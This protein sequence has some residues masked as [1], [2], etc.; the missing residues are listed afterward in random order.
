MN[1]KLVLITLLIFSQYIFTKA[2]NFQNLQF[3]QSC[4]DSLSGACHWNVSWQYHTDEIHKVPS[5]RGQSLLISGLKKSSIGFIEQAA[6]V[7]GTPALKLLTFSGKIKTENLI[8]KGAE[9]TISTYDQNKQYLFVNDLGK[10]GKPLFKG[11]QDWQ[12]FQLQAI[13]SKEVRS[14]HLGAI[15]Y[16]QG[17]AWF[18][19]FNIDIQPLTDRTPSK[20]AEEYINHFCN[21]V[22]QNSIR[23]DSID[24]PKLRAEA[25]QIAGQATEYAECHLAIKHIIS[26]LGDHHSFLMPAHT[27]K[28][29]AQSNEE[30]P[31]IPYPGHKK[32]KDFAYL[33]I[34]G[35]GSNDPGLKVA[36]VDSIQTALAYYDQQNIKGWIV[37]LRPNDG[38]NM[39][40]MLA[41]LGPL[42]SAKKV[43]YLVDVNGEKIPWGYKKNKNYF[44]TYLGV[45]ATHP[46]KL[47]NKNLPIAVLTGPNTGSSG[48]IIVLS[49]VG[50]K[51]TRSF[52]QPTFG[53]STGNGEFKLL[54]DSRVFLTSTIMADRTGKL[55]GGKVM[56]DE[57][58]ENK[59]ANG[60]DLPLLRAIEWL[61]S[62]M[63]E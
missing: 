2:Q 22:A 17:K 54:D 7:E 42:F 12:P 5:D 9:I 56:P 23:K 58:I 46:V 61:E 10:D 57:V 11:T 37:D 28:N 63:V 45:S 48:E 25:L 51:N 43:G 47:T 21:I 3:E 14:V 52:G 29:W 6:N 1:Q 53:L 16:G 31:D 20:I 19:D 26:G 62:R 60:E 59:G 41:G 34:P 38:G 35:F 39:G 36:Y 4:T 18:D 8:G 44:G 13:I 49:F 30:S 50:N 32:I 15:V 40:P 33:S 24:L 27:Y 55:Y